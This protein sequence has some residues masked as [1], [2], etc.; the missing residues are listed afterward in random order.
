MDAAEPTEQRIREAREAA[1]RRDWQHTW[2]LLRAEDAAGQ[3]S[4]PDLSLLADAAE[5]ISG[6]ATATQYRERAYAA[7]NRD[8]DLRLAARMALRLVSGYHWRGQPSVESSWLKRAE[9][10]LAELPE[11]PEH[12]WLELTRS[13]RCLLGEE[14]GGVEAAY[15]HAERAAELGRR[16]ADQDLEALASERMGSLLIKRGEVEAGLALI[17]E[18]TCAAVAGELGPQAS[19]LIYCQ[20]IDACYQLADFRRAGEWTEAMRRWCDREAVG[21]FPGTCRV[22]RAAI[23]ALRGA[24]PEAEQELNHACKE[25]ATWDLRGDLADATYELGQIRLQLGDLDEAQAA[26]HEA[27]EHGRDPQPGLAR[28]YLLQ[29]K[30]ESARTAIARALDHASNAPLARARLLPA[31]AEIAIAAGDLDLAEA[32]ATELE[33]IA[34]DY[35]TPALAANASC[36]RGRAQLTASRTSEALVNL[37]RGLALWQEVDAPYEQARTR[38]LLAEAYEQQDDPQAAELELL[39]AR[40]TFERLSALPDARRA[41]TLL[42]ARTTVD[43]VAQTFLFTDIVRSTSLAEALGDESWHNLL[44]WHDRTLRALFTQ[45]GGEEVDHAGDGFFVA[46]TSPDAALR[47]AI[48]IQRTL[49]E[50]RSTN[51]FA[52]HVRVGIHTTEAIRDGKAYRGRGIH[53]AARIAA[54]ANPDEIVSSKRTIDTAAS[55]TPTSELRSAQLRGIQEPIQVVTI[56]WHAT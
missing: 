37:R 54:L 28:L 33:T 17:D 15:A 7:A 50:H 40:S 31:Q 14:G 48:S 42:A 30:I 1:R 11:G 26:F 39:A 53:E 16:F 35:R 2:E 18:A 56:Q 55:Q 45:H 25:L 3:L 20:T 19:G 10:T 43:I 9:R 21:G 49:S 4:T 36:A 41:A 24:W 34:A 32:A 13:R 22:H 23:M 38:M 51:G 29:G 52:P 44:R 5:L 46:F 8:G 12:G 27:H 47:C 6:I